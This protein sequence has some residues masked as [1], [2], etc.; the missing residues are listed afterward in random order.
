MAFNFKVLLLHI[1][2]AIHKMNL[3]PENYLFLPRRFY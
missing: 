1:F 2:F 3:S